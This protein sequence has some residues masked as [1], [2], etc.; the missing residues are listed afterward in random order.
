MWKYYNWKWWTVCGK[1][2]AREKR[3]HNTDMLWPCELNMEIVWKWKT[4]TSFPFHPFI[5][6]LSLLPLSLLVQFFC[7]TLN[8]LHGADWMRVPLFVAV[9][10]LRFESE[11]WK[12][13][14]AKRDK[15]SSQ[16]LFSL[17]EKKG[18]TTLDNN[19][20]FPCQCIRSVCISLFFFSHLILFSLLR[21]SLYA[22]RFSPRSCLQLITLF[23][24]R[25]ASEVWTIIWL[26]SIR[27][28]HKYGRNA[29]QQTVAQTWERTSQFDESS[30]IVT[31][32]L[33]ALF[34]ACRAYY[35]YMYRWPVMVCGGAVVVVTNVIT[36]NQPNV[37]CLQ[38][39]K[40]Y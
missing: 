26:K 31:T 39:A 25:V 20:L 11:K 40:Y 22:F 5:L 6:L 19:S 37:F 27:C 7:A 30:T 21:C 29:I 8:P 13:V 35:T 9:S 24:R 17:A 32:T 16:L 10:L 36:V 18:Y 34:N 28:W 14:R 3:V 4:I 2:E 33:H 38:T 15:L 23:L 1:R 12:Q